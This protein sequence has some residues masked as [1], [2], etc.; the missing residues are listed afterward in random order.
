MS[1]GEEKLFIRLREYVLSL[2]REGVTGPD[3]I[4]L[5]VDKRCALFTLPYLLP[6]K[7]QFL[8]FNCHRFFE[9]G[10]YMAELML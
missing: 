6:Y 3:D 10:C 4:I 8:F 2:F 5:S 1:E 9:Y 7:E